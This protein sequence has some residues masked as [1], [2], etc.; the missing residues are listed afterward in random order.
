MTTKIR[1]KMDDTVEYNRSMGFNDPAGALA[2]N[3]LFA[4][5]KDI[6][7]L[8]V[9]VEPSRPSRPTQKKVDT[10]NHWARINGTPEFTLE[11]FQ[12]YFDS[13][14][15]TYREEMVRFGRTVKAHEA[16]WAARGQTVVFHMRDSRSKAFAFP[17]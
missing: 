9:P 14:M 17:K 2:Y 16:Y 11:E 4:W 15:E 1:T 5:R 8:P 12:E 7:D 6:L 3:A 10:E 13:A